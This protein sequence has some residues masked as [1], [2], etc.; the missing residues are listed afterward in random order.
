MVDALTLAFFIWFFG[1][2]Q[3]IISQTSGYHK[4]VPNEQVRS[5]SGQS[6]VRSAILDINDF[7]SEQLDYDRSGDRT[8]EPR[9]SGKADYN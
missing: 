4:I 3:V 6:L 1:Y 2:F 9:H 8:H 7:Y 5:N